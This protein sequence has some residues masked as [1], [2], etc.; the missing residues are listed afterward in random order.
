MIRSNLLNF[1]RIPIWITAIY[2]F[3]DGVDGQVPLLE[4]LLANIIFSQI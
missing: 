3:E 2:E 4:I 1:I